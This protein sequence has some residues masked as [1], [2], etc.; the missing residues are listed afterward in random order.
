[1]KSILKNSNG[2]AI[3]TNGK[4]LGGGESTLK[5]LLDT[6]KTTQYLFSRYTGT[7]VDDLIKYDDTENVEAMNNMF[8]YN[9]NL[10]SPPLL[11]TSKVKN[12]SYAFNSCSSVLEFPEYDYSIVENLR[13][14]FAGCKK[15]TTISLKNANN[16]SN[17]SYTFYQCLKLQTIDITSLDNI[18]ST[19]SM[20]WFANS[21]YVLTKLIIRTMT[22]VPPL[23][24]NSFDLCHHFNGKVNATYNPDGLKDG[25]IYV[26]DN[27]VDQLKQA[28]NWSAFADIIVPLSTLEE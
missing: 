4:L 21:C 16:V 12:M 14:T 24:T 20:S 17:Y 8:E 7:S 18:T 9:S 1:M 13:Y 26:P 23:D 3:S 28:T 5:K 2:N 11:N 27:M 15:T 10:V 19:S 22:K 6:T 25:R